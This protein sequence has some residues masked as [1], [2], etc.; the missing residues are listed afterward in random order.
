MCS[1]YHRWGFLDNPF[2]PVPLKGNELG[3]KVLIGRNSELSSVLFRLTAGGPA[4]CLDGPVGVGKTSLANVAAFRAEKNFIDKK[5][6]SPLILPCRVSFQVSKDESPESLRLKV[7]MEVAQTLLEKKAAFR[8]RGNLEH[9]SGL[10]AWLN[11]PDSTQIEI[12]IAGFGAGAS[13]QLNES[14]GFIDNGFIRLVTEWLATVFPDQATGGVVCVID[15]LELLETSAIARRTIESLRDTLFTT[16]GIR[17]ILC[18]AHGII[19][20]IV[21][22]PRLEGYLGEPVQVKRLRLQE[23]QSIFVARCEAFRDHTRPNQYLPLTADDFHSLYMILG[24]NLRQALS[25]ANKYC[26][27][28]AEQGE[29]SE[30]SSQEEKKQRFMNW[31]EASAKRISSTVESQIG[32]TTLTLLS[33]LIKKMHGEFTLDDFES[34]NL[35]SS[36]S[37]RHHIK[38]LESVGLVESTRDEIDQRRKT[39]TVTGKGWL[40]DWIRI[41]T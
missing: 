41:T 12:Q 36:S 20:S 24:E 22:S 1:F 21:E 2:A 32:K 40:I 6:N 38:T 11:H 3:N 27:A 4:V 37:F 5:P 23:A 15:N 17:W 13:T 39:I 29:S 26:L 16:N 33:D 18:G 7:L 34:L 19:H 9:S 14:Q 31:L 28:V 30:P 25:Y 10:N 8:E 35:N